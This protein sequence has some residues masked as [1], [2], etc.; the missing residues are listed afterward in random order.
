MAQSLQ[1]PEHPVN[2]I[3]VTGQ[4]LARAEMTFHQHA[5]MGA[6]LWSG[7]R[8]LVQPTQ[9]Q[10]ALLAGCNKSALIWAIKRQ[11][12][13]DAILAGILPL[14]PTAPPSARAL[15]KLNGGLTD[16]KLVELASLIGADHWL[17]AAAQAGI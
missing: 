8:H 6:D 7:A 9:E 17:H 16:D 5:F 3:A 11:Q 1:I 15:L 10:A 12:Y 14:V 13:R 2:S 4:H